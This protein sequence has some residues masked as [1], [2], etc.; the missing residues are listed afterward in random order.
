MKQDTSAIPQPGQLFNRS[1]LLKK[2]RNEAEWDLI[3]IGGGATGL[4][5]ALDAVTRGYKTLLLEQSDFSKGTS[6]KSTKLV[7]GGVRYL[8]QG[9]IDLVREALKE[10]GLLA[11]NA[12]HLVKNQKFII[13]AYD[14]FNIALYGVGLT[15]YDLLAGKLRLGRTSFL[16]SSEVM[17]RI[18]VLKQEKL[19]GGIT[20]QDGQFDDSRLALNIAQT[21]IEQGAT[22]LNY[23][24][25]N[26]L[27]KNDQGDIS[28]AEATDMETGETFTIKG[29]SVINAT[30]IF[31]DDILNM[32]Q[33]GE[34]PTVR[35]S[36]GIHLVLDK[37]FLKSE[38][39]IM[40]PK[41]SDGRVMFIIPWHNRVILGTTD[42]PIDVKSLEPKALESEINFILQTAEQ[43]LV[44][45]PKR[46]DV[47]SMYAGLRPL[48]VSSGDQTKT[49]EISRSHKII[50][51]KSGLITI[52]G[53]KW[54][55]FRKM[56]EDVVNKVMAVAGLQPSPSVSA[57]TS[58]HGNQSVTTEA[59]HLSI[60]GSDLPLLQQL[61][62]SNPE[63]DTLLCPGLEFTLAQVIFAI[64]HEMARTVEDILSR[65]VRVLY[66][67]ARKAVECAPQVAA[68]LANELS[69]D[70]QWEK[71]Q[72]AAFKKIAAGYLPYK[73][74]ESVM[75]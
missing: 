18:P 5:V 26:S 38:D 64:R 28:G 43:Y 31:V 25:V 1:R 27:L 65:R 30:G 21:C 6:S 19:T 62:D 23:I 4:G 51:S 47:L 34:K 48:A 60:Y 8:A 32:D 14:W 37:S 45:A 16:S 53:G 69:K 56:G 40:I 12:A 52:T 44:R 54:T 7:H 13:P 49:K 3:V 2:L 57:Q 15:V 10:R 33:P 68:L 36:Q 55:T 24:K 35:P 73:L 39:A 9:D 67:D 29:K 74:P 70:A 41:T 20:Y 11:R 58:I 22:L 72:V 50:V 71:E 75:N 61:I 63:W 66:L 46:T 42:T 17:K 59:D